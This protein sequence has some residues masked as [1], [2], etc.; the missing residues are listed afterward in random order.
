ML[1]TAPFALPALTHASQISV[2]RTALTTKSKNHRHEATDDL[3]EIP[4]KQRCGE[5]LSDQ[6]MTGSAKARRSY[7]STVLFTPFSAA[8]RGGPGKQ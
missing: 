1:N 4:A 6:C 2:A 5:G 7:L 8:P 3:G